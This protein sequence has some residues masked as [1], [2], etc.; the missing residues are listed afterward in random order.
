MKYLI[1][2]FYGSIVDGTPD[3]IPAL[4]IVR[5]AR[6]MDAIFAQLESTPRHLGHHMAFKSN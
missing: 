5:T 2:A 3:P 4:E 6:I 1:E